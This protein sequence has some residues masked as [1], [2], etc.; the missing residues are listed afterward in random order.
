MSDYSY[1]LIKL[2]EVILSLTYQ[3]NSS[4]LSLVHHRQWLVLPKPTQWRIHFIWRSL[5]PDSS[6]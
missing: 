6:M 3:T 4:V 5:S 2:K 1:F